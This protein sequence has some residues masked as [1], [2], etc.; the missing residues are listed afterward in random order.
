MARKSTPSTSERSFNASQK[1]AAILR[2]ESRIGELRALDITSLSTG[3]DPPVTALE[4][5]IESTL[6]NI[7]GEGTAGFSRLSDAVNLDATAY[8]F[9]DDTSVQRIREGVDR[10]RARAI[11]VLQGEVDAL[12]EDI[13]SEGPASPP[14]TA[15]ARIAMTATQP[16]SDEIFV[17]HGRDDMAKAE[18]Q[19]LVERAGLQAIVLHEQPNGGRTIIEKF[20]KHGGA[21]GFAIVILSPDDI[22]GLDV[23]SLLP[24]ARQNVIGEM[25]WFAGRLGR[26]RVCALRKGALE[27]PTDFAGVGY[28]E[29][30]GSGAWKKDVLRELEHAGY[31]QLNWQKALA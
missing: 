13:A 11:A 2:L 25:F 22:G 27:L 28:I 4:R 31:K 16:L 14:F 1:Q 21:A 20:E 7:Y 12:K 29:M 10:G 8:S 19:L 6:A 26:H 5:R 23:G 30:D 15:S 24:R 3:D 17:V 9:Y 18:V